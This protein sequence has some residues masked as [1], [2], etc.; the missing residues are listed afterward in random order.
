MRFLDFRAVYDGRQTFSTLFM[1]L[2]NSILSSSSKTKPPFIKYCPKMLRFSSFNILTNEN[3]CENPFMTVWENKTCFQ[4]DILP[5]GLTEK[6]TFTDE[7]NKKKKL[8]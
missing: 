4:E 8:N 1:L 3:P 6:K 5:G 7:N 2:S